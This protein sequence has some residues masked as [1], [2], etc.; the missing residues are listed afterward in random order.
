MTMNEQ[1]LRSIY[2]DVSSEGGY[3]SIDKLYKTAKQADKSITREQVR[4]WLRKEITY[5]LHYPARK[6]F[7]RNPVV[8]TS[9]GELAQADL[10]DMQ[11]FAG[12]NDQY[13]HI[14]TLID[15]F[16]KM[17][18]AVP[19]KSKQAPEAVRGLK[20]IFKSYRPLMIQTDRG[21]EFQNRL[22]KS[23]LEK[24]GVKLYF[25]YNRDIKASVVERF[26]RTLKSRMFKYFT[27]KGTRRYVDVLNQLIE[28]YNHSYH[29]SIRMRP[30]EVANADAKQVFENLYGYSTQR[31]MLTSK[32][33]EKAKF[34]VGDTVRLKYHTEPFDKGYYPNY[35]DKIYTIHKIIK[36]V[37]R[38]MY[39][40]KDERNKLYH[41]RVYAEELQ[42]VS[43]DIAY[44][45]EAILAH[46]TRRGVREV[47]VKWL[48]HDDSYNSWIPQDNVHGV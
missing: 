42:L 47:L 7:T 46:R 25:A 39:Y 18:F 21:G 28:G 37:P 26:N 36:Q 13:R 31:E 40:I 43:P 32:P 15:V 29:R 22:V 8:A 34:K 1:L 20:E 19:L 16:S 4:E 24:T 17:A 6:R 48:N 5:T 10:V 30:I 11:S 41:R 27:S 9:P 14:L 35:E 3:S 23:F 33:L 45:V 2:Y 38:L 44:R 12:F